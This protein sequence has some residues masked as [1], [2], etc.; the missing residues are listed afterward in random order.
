MFIKSLAG[1]R[2][3]DFGLRKAFSKHNGHIIEKWVF[4]AKAPLLCGASVIEH[5][6]RPHIVIGTKTGAII[7]VDDLGTKLWSFGT[8]E[9]LGEVE[10]YF[11]DEDRVHG[12]NAT[13]TMADVNMDGVPEILVGTER[14]VLYCLNMD[15]KLLW[16]HDCGGTIRGSVLVSDLNGDGAVEIVV[17]ST[18]NKVTMLSGMG[19]KIFEHITPA[20]VESTAGVFK[21][22][23][24]IILFGDNSGM[25]TAITPSQEVLWRI[26][27]KDKITAA[28]VM[29]N[30]QHIVVGTHGG[31][32]FCVGERG[33]LL[34]QFT[35]KGSIYSAVSV[36][37][38]NDDKQEEIVFGSCDNRIYMLSSDGK[39]MWSYETDFWVMATP[40]VT[41][42][43]SDGKMEVIAGSYDQNVYVLDSDG[44]YLL[45]YMPGL[46]GIVNQS[47][48]YSNILTSDPGE[49][50]GKKIYRF[51][52]GG[53][54]VGCSILER[55]SAKPALIVNVK[56]GKV[57]HLSHEE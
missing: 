57:N 36:C 30:H 27:L 5:N 3:M 19:K 28:P 4:D 6:N 25:L 24:T 21:G 46:G 20:S 53:I 34:W 41:D 23:N 12:I 8:Q 32:L 14:G 56:T 9:K 50:T 37:D 49:Q 1:S 52:T 17:C 47:G 42:I 38:V 16:K 33:E 31:N 35:T 18:N 39:R 15:G 48:H 10:Q 45:D 11:V 29:L 44:T 54:V 43:N 22:K 13:P 40:L 2:N 7:C 26:D 51:A 55:A